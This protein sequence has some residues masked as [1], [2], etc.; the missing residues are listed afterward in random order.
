M[1]SEELPYWQEDEN[2]VTHDPI[3]FAEPSRGGSLSDLLEIFNESFSRIDLGS[4]S[5]DE[6]RRESE[7]V[8]D[9]APSLNSK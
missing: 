1:A 7:T 6:K 3:L 8:R 4:Q 9:K 5:P 2:K